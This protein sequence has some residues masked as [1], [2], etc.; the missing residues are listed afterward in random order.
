MPCKPFSTLHR[1]TR[2]S[3]PATAHPS[4]PHGQEV[5]DCLAPI[6]QSSF[7]PHS[8]FCGHSMRPGSYSPERLDEAFCCF[9]S[10]ILPLRHHQ[11]VCR[12]VGS[13]LAV[14]HRQVTSTLQ[15]LSISSLQAGSIVPIIVCHD[16]TSSISQLEASYA[17][18][19]STC[20]CES[21]ASVQVLLNST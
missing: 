6:I 4:P 8:P 18:G 15:P 10:T 5:D 7:S 16:S 2:A 3:I 9:P 11:D 20:R 14:S 12:A 21:Q 19:S 13:S 1:P 17:R